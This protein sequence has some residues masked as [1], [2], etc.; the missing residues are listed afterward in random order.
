MTDLHVVVRPQHDKRLGRQVV[1]DDASRS[2]ARTAS[3]IELSPVDPS[4]W[5]T[6]SIRIYDPL[7]NPNQPV[8]CC[9]ACAKASMFNSVGNRRMGVVLGM[10]WALDQYRL[11]TRIDP[12]EGTW[13]PV[14]TGSSSLASCK[15]AQQTGEGGEYRYDFRGA[16]GVVQGIC[17]DRRV[18]DVGTWWR[19]GMFEPNSKGIIEPTGGYAGGHQYVARGYDADRDL[20]LIR[21][22]WGLSYRDVWIKREHL[23]DL[24]MDDGDVHTQRRL[25]LAA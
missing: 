8:G 10:D 17:G 19:W 23:N 22:W 16:D 5:Y 7:P 20:I 9:T 6:T 3:T 25:I 18:Q 13:E 2:F 11:Y 24:I 1:H 4:T 15:G 21:C 14:D 12:F